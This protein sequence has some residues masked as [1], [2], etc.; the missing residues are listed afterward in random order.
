MRSPPAP[1]A[2]PSNGGAFVAEL[3]ERFALSARV[4]DGEEEARLTY[5]GATAERPPA[6]PTLVVDIGGGSTELIVG[7]ARRSPSTPRCRPAS[8]AT[9]SA[10]SPPTRRPPASWRRSPPTCAG[11]IEARADA[12]AAQAE[13]RDRGRRHA[14]LAGRDRAGARPLR[15]RAGPRPRAQPGH[16]PATALAARLRTALG[17]GRD[18]RPAP[19]PGADDRRRRR[20]PDRGD[21]GLRARPDRGLRARHPLR[22]GDLRRREC[23]NPRYRIR[24]ESV[25]PPVQSRFPDP[26]RVA[27]T[28]NGTQKSW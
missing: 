15:P 1:S 18:R 10:T 21:A 22:R 28:T 27:K 3:R 24:D 6:E 16:D 11:L 17:A 20:D 8:S 26:D 7:R 5:L 25:G 19:R 13:R 4:L 9:P 23:G 14:D 2:T 12:D